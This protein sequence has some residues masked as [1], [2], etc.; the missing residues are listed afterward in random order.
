MLIVLI[1]GAFKWFICLVMFHPKPPQ[2]KMSFMLNLNAYYPF[3]LCQSAYLKYYSSLLACGVS[4][5][6]DF[7]NATLWG[8]L[9][10]YVNLELAAGGSISKLAVA[11]CLISVPAPQQGPVTSV[12]L[13]HLEQRCLDLICGPRTTITT[14]SL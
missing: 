13:H 2:R 11:H 8:T 9:R 5:P 12:W 3:E 10:A 14:D 7:G 6:G 1:K 4:S